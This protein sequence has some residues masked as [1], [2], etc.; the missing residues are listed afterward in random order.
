M[1]NKQKELE[2]LYLQ[3]KAA[4]YNS[5][6][7]MSDAQFDKLEDELKALGSNLTSLVGTGVSDL[8]S[9]SKKGK[10]RI[11][12][13]SQEKVNQAEELEKW[14]SLRYKRSEEPLFHVSYKADGGSICLYYE[15]GVLKEALTRGD[16]I[17]GEVITASAACFKGVPKTLP[18]PLTIGVRCEA[19]L[20]IEDWQILDPEQ[21][22]NPRNVATG[23][24]GRLDTTK[25]HHITSLAFDLDVFGE[26]NLFQT[27]SE[28]Y[29]LL[30][31]LG[32]ETI[33]WSG[34]LGLNGVKLFYERTQNLREK[35]KIP[36]WIDGII[37]RYEDIEFQ[38]ELGIVSNR[39]KGQIAWKFP[40]EG[41]KSIIESIHWQVGHTGAITP[42]AT[43]TP[44]K[45][46]G[47]IV[48]KAS[49]ANVDNIKKLGVFLG[50]EVTVVKAGDIIPAIIEVHNQFDKGTHKHIEIPTICPDCESPVEKKKN[51]GGEE[52]AVIY[53][54]SDECPSKGLG[55]IKRFCKSRDI[56]GLGDAVIEALMDA[57]IVR[58]VPD[59]YTL[60]PRKMESISV[61]KE[62]E[63]KL[64]FKRAES[65]CKEIQ[66]KGT[67][68]SLPEFLGA[69]GT[70]GLGVRR[71]TLM[72]EANPELNKLETWFNGSLLNEEFSAK[73]KVPNLG[74]VIYEGLLEKEKTIKTTL[75]F[76]EII[77]TEKKEEP[78]AKE[79][80]KTFCITGS[81]PSG[82]KKAE[83]F[84]PLQKAGHLLLDEV[85]AGLDFL[86]VS[87]PSIESSK[88]KKAKKLGVALITEEEMKKFLD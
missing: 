2:E 32:F 46:G 15:N 41:E 75:N 36:F 10:H 82:K 3:A 63:I 17:T 71:A 44:V 43:V 79:G 30:I 5:E 72:C 58:T 38:K 42:V 53:C 85:K 14:H 47:T 52:T 50:A 68:M 29:K 66:E 87:D 70:R 86:V 20:K 56:L 6:P 55:A 81:L 31:S 40:A 27:E 22:T 45:I 49:L 74:S 1:K 69:F 37:V 54:V 39:P 83:Y 62:K 11:H 23:I 19:I 18:K 34:E 28:K 78:K 88:T 7:I 26:E 80:G 65:I 76:I 13:G 33:P 48:T 61:N 4:Y 35:D 24:L 57:E 77:A 64:G 51:I 21:K 8:T 16:G 25:A 67:K 12:M 60:S 84:H 73:A 59:L 9:Q